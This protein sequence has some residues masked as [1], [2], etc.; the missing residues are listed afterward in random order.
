MHFRFSTNVGRALLL[1]LVLN[2]NH[3]NA[4]SPCP[5]SPCADESTAFCE[6]FSDWIA[7]GVITEISYRSF[8]N[9]SGL[10]QTSGSRIENWKAR[11][12][13]I[14][15]LPEKNLKGKVPKGE[16]VLPLLGCYY[17][18]PGIEQMRPQRFIVRVS[19]QKR[20]DGKYTSLIHYKPAPAAAKN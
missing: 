6:S 19:V 18:L 11:A 3:A 15:F 8:D 9:F 20:P 17:P 5:R 14:T 7:E 16:T 2:S 12:V 13:S 4:T 10:P 1:Y